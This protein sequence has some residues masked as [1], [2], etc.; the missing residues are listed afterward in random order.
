MWARSEIGGG[1]GGFVQ[2]ERASRVT[3]H[4]LDNAQACVCRL[5]GG[6]SLA[7]GLV[8]FT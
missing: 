3:G 5:H 6:E 8:L 4:G 1:G 2:R 7:G